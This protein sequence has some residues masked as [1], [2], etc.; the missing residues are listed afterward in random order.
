M[1]PFN[2]KLTS[3]LANRYFIVAVALELMLALVIVIFFWTRQWEHDDSL[4][5]FRQQSVYSENQIRFELEQQD[6]L[7]EQLATLFLYDEKHPVTREGFHHYVANVFHRFPMIQALEWAPR[8]KSSERAYYES[9][10]FEVRDRSPEGKLQ[11][12]ADRS[13]YFPV[14]YV[15]PLEGNEPAIGFDLA[16]SIERKE[17]LVKALESGKS[18]TSEPITLVQESQHQAGILLLLG[19]KNKGVVLTVLRVGDFIDRLLPETRSSHYS[20]LI[21]VEENKTIY[22]NFP[23]GMH[24]VL[25]RDSFEFG[26]RHYRFESSPSNAYFINHKH[27]E[28]WI[29]LGIGA[30]I[31]ALISIL[32][33]TLARRSEGINEQVKERTKQL[34]ESEERWQFALEGSGDG[35]WDWNIK[36]D[37]ALFSKRWKELLGF[38]DEEFPNTGSAFIEHLHPDDS[39]RVKKVIGDYISGGKE[40]YSVEF[41]MRCKD[42]SWKWIL[43][44]GKL[45]R[46]DEEGN[47]L[48]MIGTHTDISVRKAAEIEILKSKEK[49]ETANQAKSNFLANMSHEIRTPMSGVIG[50]SELALESNDLGEMHGYLR[51]INDS[52]RSLLRILNDILDLSKIEAG[53]VSLENTIFNLDDV[54]DALRRTFT[55]NANEK[56][57]TF[58]VDCDVK[59]HRMLYGDPLRIRQILTNLLGNAFKFTS[60]G[61]VRLNVTQISSNESSATLNFEVRD[62][63]IGMTNEQVRTLFKPFSQV[64]SSISRRFGGT[65]LGLAIS[66]DFA[67]IM[68]GDINVECEIEK[69]CTFNFEITLAFAKPSQKDNQSSEE[70]KTAHAA[71]ETLSLLKGKLVLLAEDNAINQIVASKLL[72]KIGL[73]VDVANNGKEAIELLSRK[74]YDFVLMDIQMPVMDGLEATRSIRQDP[75]F[76]TLPIIAMSAGVT[77]AEKTACNDAGMTDFI[78]KPIDSA[79]LGRKLSELAS[80]G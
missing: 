33:F 79:E 51:Q 75:R 71:E 18:V 68:G 37:E 41:R 73:T 69:G 28:S 36:T 5:D 14:T 30:T 25:Y 35:V 39:E 34:L 23:K 20:R 12:A 67:R 54:L 38:T 40:V 52:S 48:R 61:E 60:K 57:I 49:A 1:H 76:R 55:L 64:D 17:A 70:E 47:P 50:L 72:K 16:S 56:G 32:L 9:S 27:S 42:G 66:R 11:R 26:S 44:R 10:N 80:K 6:F 13:E 31:S 62:T 15:E 8:V 65:G 78:A 22:D 46:V 77:L 3:L 45:V 74:P 43:A 7:L 63:G 19:V 53:Q 24:P 29:E 2:K 4:S 58:L 59:I 21:D